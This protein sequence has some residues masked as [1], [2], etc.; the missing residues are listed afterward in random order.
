MCGRYVVV[1]KISEIEERF[2]VHALEPYNPNFNIGPGSFAPVI[3]DK[4]PDK[5]QFF[6]F[7]MTPFW[8]KKKLYFFNARAEG[9]HN[10]EDDPNYHGAM[11]IISKPAFRK[12]IRSQR[13]LVIA[14][15]F[16]E[17]TT[18]KKLDEPFVVHLSKGQRPFA[19]AGIWDEWVDQETGEVVNSF[20]IITTTPNK[21]LQMLPHHRSP[22][23]LPK[24]KEREWLNPDLALGEV[25][26]MLR[27]Y[28][29]NDMNA[30]PIST[31]IK[32][33]RSNGVELLKPTG[34]AVATE[35][36]LVV[37]QELL[38]EGMGFTRARSRPRD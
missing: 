24:G 32:N 8:A 1:S 26:A 23:I 35:K 20:A 29:A 25:T 9:D 27:P 31:A 5:L 22:V 33:P 4:E 18:A 36:A 10:K 19:F 3:T 28:E 21:L 13:C 7:G 11:G 16:I 12:A 14:D 34:P 30:Y 6:Q 15:A 2:G 38:L 17:G 37:E